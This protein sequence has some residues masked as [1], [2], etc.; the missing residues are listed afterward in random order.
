MQ[1]ILKFEKLLYRV[2]KGF[3][4]FVLNLHQTS[5]IYPQFTQGYELGDVAFP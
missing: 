3:F 4:G 2:V 1:L 5:I